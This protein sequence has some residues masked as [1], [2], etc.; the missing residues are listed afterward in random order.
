MAPAIT[1]SALVFLQ[2]VIGAFVA[3]TNAGFTINTWPSMDGDLIPPGLFDMQPW[4]LSVVGT[5][6]AKKTLILKAA[7]AL[8]DVK[9]GFGDLLDFMSE[10]RCFRCRTWPLD[11]G[12]RPH[13]SV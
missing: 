10:P 4:W 9:S 7:I 11:R 12:C 2:I 13:K 5:D 3:G 6:S 1:V 8:D